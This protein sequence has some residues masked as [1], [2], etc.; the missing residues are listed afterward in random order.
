MDTEAHSECKTK[1]MKKAQ[2]K[3]EDAKSGKAALE[4]HAEYVRKHALSFGKCWNY[5]ITFYI[6]MF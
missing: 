3:L 1:N 4:K 6:T 2:E 5:V